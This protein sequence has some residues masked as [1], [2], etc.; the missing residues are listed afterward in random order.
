MKD[1]R[2]EWNKKRSIERYIND[3]VRDAAF[4]LY[5]GH[6]FTVVA[7]DEHPVSITELTKLNYAIAWKFGN[8]EKSFNKSQFIVFVLIMTRSDA[9]NESLLKGSDYI[10]DM[11]QPNSGVHLCDFIGADS[12]V[13]LNTMIVHTIRDIYGIQ[14]MTQGFKFREFGIVFK[15]AI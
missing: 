12:S 7:L 13:R 3:M 14:N 5:T 10:L 1:R 6:K 2:S 8:M 15:M 9:G 4:E 11:F